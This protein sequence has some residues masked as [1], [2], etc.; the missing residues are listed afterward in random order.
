[1]RAAIPYD[2]DAF[3][4]HVAWRSCLTRLEDTFANQEFVARIVEVARDCER[5]PLAGPNRSQLLELLTRTT[6]CEPDRRAGRKAHVKAHIFGRP[7]HS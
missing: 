6:G 1:L 3:R 2:A 5:P 4:A 7:Q